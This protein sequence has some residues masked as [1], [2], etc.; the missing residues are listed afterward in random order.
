[1]AM[2]S[3]LMTWPINFVYSLKLKNRIPEPTIYQWECWFIW[4]SDFEFF[5]FNFI[6]SFFQELNFQICPQ[7]PGT[8]HTFVPHNPSGTCNRN[9]T[10]Y[11]TSSSN[12]SF[13]PL[14]EPFGFIHFQ[15]GHWTFNSNIYLMKFSIFNCD[16]HHRL[17]VVVHPFQSQCF[18]NLPTLMNIYVRY[19]EMKKKTFLL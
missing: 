9:Y 8:N 18:K 15:F 10:F 3:G 16:H 2:D 12:V 19:C 7:V 6:L 17:R 5:P 11:I 1:M 13:L 4:E 14:G